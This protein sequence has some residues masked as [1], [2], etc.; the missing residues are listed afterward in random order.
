MFEMFK[1]PF[2]ISLVLLVVFLVVSA[3]QQGKIE[4]STA[5]L[6]NIYQKHI[7][8]VLGEETATGPKPEDTL[9]APFGASEMAPP[10]AA[11]MKIGLDEAHMENQKVSEWLVAVLSEMLMVMPDIYEEKRRSLYGS[12][13]T[14][15]L[16]DYDNFLTDNNIMTVLQER[17]MMMAG[18][19]ED[20]P[21]LLQSGNFDGIYRWV[22]R[23]PVTVTVMGRDTKNYEDFDVE[24]EGYNLQLSIQ[25]QIGRIEKDVNEMGLIIERLKF[26]SR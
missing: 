18:F 14:A 8:P 26:T 5:F 23:V 17:N 10:A 1:T 3:I 15:A 24:T 16:Q 21:T 25:A 22:Y 11:E 19:A 12:V 7:R 2:K 20:Q 4:F 6:D 13:D 9:V